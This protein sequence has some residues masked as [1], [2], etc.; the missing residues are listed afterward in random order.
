MAKINKTY[1]EKLIR[2]NE[3]LFEEKAALRNLS[4]A[5]SA[6]RHYL[7][8]YPDDDQR[9]MDLYGAMANY[10][11]KK[12]TVENLEREFEKQ[13]MNLWENMED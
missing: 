4:M 2:I 8:A 6:A 1:H 5:L 9:V 7:S 12:A 11:A 13:V 10:N 3:T